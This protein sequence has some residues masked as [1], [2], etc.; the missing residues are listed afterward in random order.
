MERNDDRVSSGKAFGIIILV[1]ILT[2]GLFVAPVSLS[3]KVY[4]Y[5]FV[6][7]VPAYFAFKRQFALETVNSV[8]SKGSIWSNLSISGKISYVYI[9]CMVIF[10][11]TI[12]F[13]RY[14]FGNELYF[15][16]I[17][18]GYVTG[19]T[20]LI[21]HWIYKLI[22]EK[23][24]AVQYISDIFAMWLIGYGMVWVSIFFYFVIIEGD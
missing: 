6:L 7:V 5:I 8:F 16:D 4:L 12:Q 3:W 21:I 2:L 10:C 15:M 23:E 18:L 13:F 1:L 24:E 11:G 19:A 22:R 14:Y 17:T 20:P 9:I